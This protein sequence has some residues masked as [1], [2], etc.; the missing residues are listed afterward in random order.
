[1]VCYYVDDQILSLK[2]QRESPG[3]IKCSR[4]L[5]MSELHDEVSSTLRYSKLNK[6]TFVCSV[7]IKIMRIPSHSTVVTITLS[8]E[9]AMSH[10]VNLKALLW[11]NSFFLTQESKEC[12]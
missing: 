9:T 11:T 7:C 12:Q 10:M 6:S 1:M 4:L 8:H 2:I 3:D 5:K